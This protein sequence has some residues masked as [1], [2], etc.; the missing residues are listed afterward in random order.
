MAVLLGLNP[1][2][3]FTAV[4]SVIIIGTKRIAQKCWEQ[5]KDIREQIRGTEFYLG[6]YQRYSIDFY[7][8]K[9]ETKT[10]ISD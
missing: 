8:Y 1:S 4:A 7:A 2:H 6:I 10:L 5:E 9:W 3:S